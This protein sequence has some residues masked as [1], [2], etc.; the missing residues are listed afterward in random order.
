MT[1]YRFLK[2]GLFEYT[3]SCGGKTVMDIHPACIRAARRNYYCPK[4]GRQIRAESLRESLRK[5]H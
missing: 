5:E 4:C 2:M 3:H 1:V